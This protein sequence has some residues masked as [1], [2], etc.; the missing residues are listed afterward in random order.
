MAKVAAA[1]GA[2]FRNVQAKPGNPMLAA[3]RREQSRNL[4]QATQPVPGVNGA[5]GVHTATGPDSGA[6]SV[7]NPFER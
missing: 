4:G 2:A 5:S 3:A 6:E 7:L 1:Y